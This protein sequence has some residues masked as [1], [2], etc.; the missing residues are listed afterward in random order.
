MREEFALFRFI[1]FQFISSSQT[2]IF[3]Y[4]A[5]GEFVVVS[6]KLKATVSEEFGGCT[7]I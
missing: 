7:S 4:P 3:A 1:A 5:I 6:I 2:S